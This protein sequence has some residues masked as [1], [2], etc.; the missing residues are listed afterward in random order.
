LYLKKK[1]MNLTLGSKLLGLLFSLVSLC[2]A[3][4]HSCGNTQ[5]IEGDGCCSNILNV[6]ANFTRCFNPATH[7]CLQ[8]RNQGRMALCPKNYGFCM[9]QCYNPSLYSCIENNLCGMNE[10][11]CGDVCYDV[12]QLRCFR[13]PNILC[14]PNDELCGELCYDPRS[15]S[16]GGNKQLQQLSPAS[17]GRRE[18]NSRF[19]TA[20]EVC[21][22]GETRDS[23]PAAECFIPALFSCVEPTVSTKNFG[24]TVCPL[25]F[26]SCPLE[27]PSHPVC[28]N[29]AEYYCNQR[30]PGKSII[31]PIGYLSSQTDNSVSVP[32][33]CMDT[34]PEGN[35]DISCSS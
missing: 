15:F 4:G 3:A 10:R 19:C 31:C 28:I 9:N 17:A 2:W 5:C 21:C 25:G 7:S 23:Q 35:P 1:K 12:S 8:T 26:V 27:D 20:D 29:A 30:F 34:C 13:G 24:R 22:R 16:C 18:C 6:E 32:A 14:G 33:G 11:L